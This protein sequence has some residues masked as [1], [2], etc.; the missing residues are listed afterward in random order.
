MVPGSARLMVA[1]VALVVPWGC[2]GGS[3]PVSPTSAPLDNELFASLEARQAFWCESIVGRPC[4]VVL[5]SAHPEY[6]AWVDWSLKPPPIFWNE[7]VLTDRQFWMTDPRMAH[8][9]CHLKHGLQPTWT[10]QQMEAYADRCA[11]EH[12]GAAP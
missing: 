2:G 6:A 4:S 11:I 1:L 9:A 8:E 7:R 5:S 12:T 3:S 10:L